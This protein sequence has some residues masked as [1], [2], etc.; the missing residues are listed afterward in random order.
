YTPGKLLLNVR[1]KQKTV[2]TT[3][4]SVLIIELS[5]ASGTQN[6]YET[7]VFYEFLMDPRNLNK[8]FTIQDLRVG[9]GKLEVKG[10]SVTI[11]RDAYHNIIP[12]VEVGTPLINNYTRPSDA[13]IDNAD[14]ATFNNYVI[15]YNQTRLNYHVIKIGRP[16]AP[17][18]KTKQSFK[19]DLKRFWAQ[20]EKTVNAQIPELNKL[21]QQIIKDSEEVKKYKEL[22][23]KVN[24]SDPKYSKHKGKFDE[25]SKK[26]VDGVSANEDLET[27]ATPHLNE[28][29][30]SDFFSDAA[31]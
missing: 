31:H 25:E 5:K 10:H 21:R 8:D 2:G 19:D 15:D 6:Q 24:G 1:V 23:G 14:D 22:E 28:I 30:E 7:D 3:P 9:E 13:D 27:I 26:S 29:P 12:P 18:S 16:G 17:T 11:P 20:F 4:V